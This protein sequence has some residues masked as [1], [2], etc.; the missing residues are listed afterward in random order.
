MSAYPDVQERVH[1]ELKEVVG[2][3]GDKMPHLDDRPNTPYTDA[4]LEELYRHCPM[5][6]INVLHCTTRDVSFRGVIIPKDTQVLALHRTIHDDPKY[7][8]EPEVF[9][10]ERFLKQGTLK[11][12]TLIKLSC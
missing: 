4:T 10:P 8:P 6:D 3:R 7:F 12:A 5:T 11:N 2:A 1:S 9:K